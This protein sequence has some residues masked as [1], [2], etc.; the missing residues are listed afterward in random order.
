[1]AERVGELLTAVL[2]R[3]EIVA[4]DH[5]H[6]VHRHPRPA[7]RL[8]GRRRPGDRHRRRPA[9]PARVELAVEERH[10]HGLRP[11]QVSTRRTPRPT[12]RRVRD[13]PRLRCERPTVLP[14]ART[15][16]QSEPPCRTGSPGCA[17]R[18][19]RRRGR[20]WP[21]TRA[22]TSPT[23]PTATRTWSARTAAAPRSPWTRSS[24]RRR[25][26]RSWAAAS[27]PRSVRRRPRPH[28][29]PAS[30]ATAVRDG[31]ARRLP[32]TSASR[33]GRPAL[34][35][36]RRSASAAPRPPARTTLAG[37]A[38]SPPPRRARA[39]PLR[40][41]ALGSVA[42]YPREHRAPSSPPCNAGAGAAWE[43][44]ALAAGAVPLVA[45]TPERPRPRP[46]PAPDPRSLVCDTDSFATT[47]WHARYVGGRRS[48]LVRADR[49]P[50]RPPPA[51]PHRPRGRRLRRRR[52]ARRRG[53]CAAWTPG[54]VRA[55]SSPAPAAG[56]SRMTV[57]A[58]R[59]PGSAAAGAAE[60][61]A[62]R[63]RLRTSCGAAPSG[64]VDGHPR[65]PT[66]RPPPRTR[67]SPC[68]SATSRASWPR[69]SPTAGRAGLNIEDVRIEHATGQQARPRPDHGR[70]Q[71]RPGPRSGAPGTR[72]VDPRLTR[73]G[74]AGRTHR[75]GR[76]VAAPARSAPPRRRPQPGGPADPS[77]VRGRARHCGNLVRGRS[78]V[79]VRPR[80]V[81]QEGVHHRG[82]RT[83][84]RDRRHR[85]ALGHRKV[86]HLQGRRRRARP[87]LPGHGRAVPGHHLVDADQRRRR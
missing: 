76:G 50:G 66:A 3:N 45:R 36:R 40:G 78:R 17:T 87:E 33:H 22:S 32:G 5:E 29:R 44:V 38:R 84:L 68:S 9:R 67:P 48:P 79:P 20:R 18:T 27:A 4:D 74:R 70:T 2:E 52:T 43:D 8:P 11:R 47:V 39:G 49:R 81:Y 57:A 30:S 53:A 24:P 62:P 59:G 55:P 21:A 14:C 54:P 37:K 83:L 77:G 51:A 31:V 60:R 7:Q 6:P 10:G 16:A 72:L 73:P 85:R 15:S 23:P 25:P 12:T 35:R 65:P 71:R 41:P 58:L 34:A 56:S 42:P 19:S 69:S 26:G 13:R 61:R 28:A 86:E 75:A 82:N 63:H 64:H 1:M 46:P 80:P